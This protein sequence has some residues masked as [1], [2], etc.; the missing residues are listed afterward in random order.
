MHCIRR[1]EAMPSRQPSRLGCQGQIEF[2]PDY[3]AGWK[4]LIDDSLFV[5]SEWCL[6]PPRS[7]DLGRNER[8]CDDR[9]VPPTGRLEDL[10]RDGRAIDL[11]I[12]RR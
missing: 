1:L 10:S 2:D 5:F 8:G 4:D 6:L 11:I 7:N 9:N 3:A 12:N